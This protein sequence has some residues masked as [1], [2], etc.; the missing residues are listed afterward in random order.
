MWMGAVNR[1]E[2]EEFIYERVTHFKYRY[3]QRSLASSLTVTH[4]QKSLYVL[5]P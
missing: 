3:G 1:I 2:K 4:Y 5:G